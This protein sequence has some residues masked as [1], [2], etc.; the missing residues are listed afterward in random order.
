MVVWARERKVGTVAIP[1]KLEVES[2][3]F[4]KELGIRYDILEKTRGQK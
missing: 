2:L 3:R 1:D 4:M